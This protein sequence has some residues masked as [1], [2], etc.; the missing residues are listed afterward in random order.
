MSFNLTPINISA[1]T[2]EVWVNRTNSI[3][4]ALNSNV[5]SADATSNGSITTGNSFVNGI[6][7][8]T[9]LVAVS[10]LRGGN[11]GT[12]NTLNI[13]SN[14]SFTNTV[15][16][17]AN[18]SLTGNLSIINAAAITS[19]IRGGNS[20]VANVLSVYS[21]IYVTNTSTISTLNVTT[22]GTSAQLLDSF[23]LTSIRTAEYVVS[24]KDNTAN[25]YQAEK[26]LVLQNGSNVDYTEHAIVLSNSHIATF[27]ANANSTHIRLYITPTSANTTIK[28]SRIA[29]NI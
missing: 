18:I 23:E 12:S 15:Y 13:S 4:S 16:F 14:V 20:S 9:T 22:T 1:D 28:G 17:S 8:A 2:F 29:I 7:A 5:V 3:I 6:F 19:Y 21:N 24:V 11:V 10:G 26:I 27:D 25:N